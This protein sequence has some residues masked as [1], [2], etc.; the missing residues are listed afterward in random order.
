MRAD[1]SQASLHCSVCTKVIEREGRSGSPP[2][3]CSDECHKERRK[4]LRS[5]ED[6]K[7]C[8]YCSRPST[9]AQR[10]AFRRWEKAWDIAQTV[11]QLP[12]LLGFLRG[13]NGVM[14]QAEGKKLANA[15]ER[16]L[17]P[18]PILEKDDAEP[19]QLR[20]EAERWPVI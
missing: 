11:E 20:E 15:L 7:Y 12:A 13:A 14:S 6:Q 9:P 17:D 8:R 16:V 2:V 18:K 1:L 3:V 4:I 19:H 10:A 5:R